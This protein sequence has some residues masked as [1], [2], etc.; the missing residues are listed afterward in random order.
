MT[1]V[2]TEVNLYE[3][4]LVP[5]EEVSTE[6]LFQRNISWSFGP[7]TIEVCYSINAVSVVAK[8]AGVKIGQATLTPSNNG[9]HFGTNVGVAKV[10]INL[11]AD[12]G[13]KELNVHGNA[14]VRKVIVFPP[15]F[16]WS[17]SNFNEVIFHW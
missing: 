9:V 3:E 4:E 12:F 14:C 7:L 5:D 10:D 17:C 1:E 13:K 15:S 16:K 8:V 2:N 6:Q 11:S